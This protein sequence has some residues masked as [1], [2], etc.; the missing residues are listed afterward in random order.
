MSVVVFQKDNDATSIPSQCCDYPYIVNGGLYYNCTVN[1]A[2]SND[3]GCYNDNGQW[4]TCEQPESTFTLGEF[5]YT[6]RVMGLLQILSNCFQHFP[7]FKHSIWTY[8]P[9]KGWK[10]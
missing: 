8:S 7:C 5:I 10:Q 4:V 1:P 3:F 6:S 9:D 2:F